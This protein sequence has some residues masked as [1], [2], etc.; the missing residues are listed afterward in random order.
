MEQEKFITILNFHCNNCQT[1]IGQLVSNAID[2]NEIKCP[3]CKSTN[4]TYSMLLK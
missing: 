4:I 3:H 1:N 2:E